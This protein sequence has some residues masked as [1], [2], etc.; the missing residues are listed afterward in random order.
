MPRLLKTADKHERHLARNPLF[1]VAT[2]ALCLTF[3]KII[4]ACA[5]YVKL[6]INYLTNPD[7]KLVAFIQKQPTYT[8][9]VSHFK[10]NSL[11]PLNQRVPRILPEIRC[12]VRLYLTLQDVYDITAQ[13]SESYSE[14]S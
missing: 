7:L 6:V 14:Q 11:K 5:L 1:T 8:H 10:A 12:N 13:Y 3:T 9:F 4:P 2:V